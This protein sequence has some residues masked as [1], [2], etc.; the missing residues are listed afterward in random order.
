VVTAV[1][2]GAMLLRSEAFR[3]VGGMDPRF[4]VYHEEV[5]LCLR[6]RKEGWKIVFAP[7]AQVLHADALSTGYKTDRL[8]MEPVLSWRL[9]GQSILFEKHFT[10]SQHRKFVKMASTVLKTRATIAKLGAHFA[11]AKREH[12]FARAEE[13]R[14][15]AARL[16][17]KAAPGN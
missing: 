10:A 2:G 5:D 1:S 4:F 9:N 6:L 16:Q 7:Q 8:P 14:S 17:G 15:A 13:L 11:G 3:R 12:L